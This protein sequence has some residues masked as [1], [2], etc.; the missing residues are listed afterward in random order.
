[1]GRKGESSLGGWMKRKLQPSRKSQNKSGDPSSSRIGSTPLP[2]TP[3]I[4]PN[5][6]AAEGEA[7]SSLTSSESLTNAPENNT[8]SLNPQPRTLDVPSEEAGESLL[9]R[10]PG[11]IENPGEG[12]SYHSDYANRWLEGVKLHALERLKDEVVNMERANTSPELVAK[13]DENAVKSA[14]DKLNRSTTFLFR[15]LS[16]LS[17]QWHP[18][19]KLPK[20]TRDNLDESIQDAEAHIQNLIEE[21]DRTKEIAAAKKGIVHNLGNGAKTICVHIKPFLQTFLAVAVQGSAVPSYILYMLISR[22]H[23]SILLGYWRAVSPC[24]LT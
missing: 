4:S 5:V 2:S 15:I 23:F 1:M 17:N 3:A 22:F 18:D 12:I 21:N 7:K 9:K 6:N 20:L 24:L 16:V 11:D 19:A 13:D 8:T 14:R 10:N